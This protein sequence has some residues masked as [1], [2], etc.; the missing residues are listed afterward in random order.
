M[1]ATPALAQGVNKEKAREH[2]QNGK[3][4]FKDGDYPAALHEY[5]RAYSEA[6]LPGF[7]FNIGQCYR[8]MNQHKEA[9]AS[10]SRYLEKVPNAQ[11]K[12][13]VETLIHELEQKIKAHKVKPKPVKPTPV[14]PEP[15]KPKPVKPEPVKPKNTVPTYTPP[16]EDPAQ[17][18]IT[19]TTPPPAVTG[20]SSTPV[21]KKWWFWTIIAVAAGGGAVGAYFGTRS[22]E[23]SIPPSQLGMLDFSR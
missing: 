10:F 1:T 17:A 8:N 5:K 3:L 2:Y 14:K 9:I 11:N 15:V 22:G 7:L 18:A 23:A 6:P 4:A 12:A 19:G 21:Y 16:K 13:A 20:E